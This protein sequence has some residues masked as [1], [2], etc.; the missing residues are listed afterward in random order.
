MVEIW[1]CGKYNMLYLINYKPNISNNGRIYFRRFNKLHNIGFPAMILLNKKLTLKYYENNILHREDGP[2]V[3]MYDEKNKIKLKAY[4]TRGMLHREDGPALIEYNKNGY[5]EKIHY[6]MN[7]IRHRKDGPAIIDYYWN[8]SKIFSFH[9]YYNDMLH[10]CPRLISCYPKIWDYGPAEVY[11]NMNG[12][13][14]SEKYYTKGKLNRI[15]NVSDGPAL[16]EYYDNGKIKCE[17]YYI[18]GTPGRLK[19][20]HI[21]EYYPNNKVK[22]EAYVKGICLHREDGPAEIKYTSN[23]SIQYEKYYI[24]GY[25]I[26]ETNLY[27]LTLFK[28]YLGKLF[29]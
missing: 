23:G 26:S 9:Y 7:D 27:L 11:Y 20:P 10:R 21:I 1:I 22:W 28:Y 5:V 16:V 2:A 17:E 13:P 24:D 18:S 6:Y 12:L 29:N 8:G 25:Y 15:Q 14:I 4:Y 19:G 3:I